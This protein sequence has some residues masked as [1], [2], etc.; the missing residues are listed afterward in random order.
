MER[1]VIFLLV[2]NVKEHINAGWKKGQDYR[3]SIK[4]VCKLK[5]PIFLDDLKKHKVIRT[6]SFVRGSRQGRPGVTEYWPY[7]YDMIIKRN[8]D[9]IKQLQKYVPD[10]V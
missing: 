6:S 10:R 4:R 3:V 7:L 9:V 2:S 1:G 8:R 5:S